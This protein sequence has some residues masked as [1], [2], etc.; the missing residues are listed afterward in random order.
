MSDNSSNHFAGD[1]ARTILFQA[2]QRQYDLILSRRNTL[3]TQ[4]SSL[5]TFGGIINT[6]LV[7]LLIALGSSAN[8][9]PLLMSNPFIQY[10]GI[11]IGFGFV[12]YIFAVVLSLSAFIEVPWVPAPQIVY[13]PDYKT[14][15]TDFFSKLKTEFETYD[16]NPSKIPIVLYELQL[17]QAILSHLK[18]N[19]RKFYLIAIGFI[20]L[21]VGIILTALAGLLMLFGSF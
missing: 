17:S 9:K 18:T 20:L 8:G 13:K 3:N 4:A 11:C 7:G 16:Q 6:V 1:P 14:N 5:M 10:I 21:I 2:T 15:E 19:K 12:L